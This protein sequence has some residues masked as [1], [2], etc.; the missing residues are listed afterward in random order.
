MA[1][2]FLV[3]GGIAVGVV[4][5]TFGVLQVPGWVTSAQDA[6]ATD[7]LAN[8]RT[9]QALA[10]SNPDDPS[11]VTDFDS[12]RS[13]HFGLQFGLSQNTELTFLDANEDSWCAVVKSGSGEYLAA[14]S[15]AN[16]IGRGATQRLAADSA[17]C[18]AF[19]SLDFTRWIETRRNL[20]VNPRGGWFKPG[21][22]GQF[23]FNRSRWVDRGTYSLEGEWVRFTRHTALSGGYGFH[24]S[25]NPEETYPTSSWLV[26]V[27]PGEEF[28][29]SLLAR[30]S[31]GTTTGFIGWRFTDENNTWVTANRITAGTPVGTTATQLTASFTVPAGA[32]RLA[33]YTRASIADGEIA[34]GEYIEATQL[35]IEKTAA[36]GT[37]FDGG[38]T[39][40]D[41]E[42]TRTRW[43]GEE[44]RSQ[45][46]TETRS[47]AD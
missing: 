24:I 12:L 16:V 1:N 13:G 45:S 36:P 9:A 6:A 5:A 22:D 18:Y 38:T 21:N 39:S 41:P 47:R 3:L 14:G 23:G 44:G 15:D 26:P 43:L 40:A 30:I 33:L 32:T 7:D 37:F 2:P 28:S 10:I 42:L 17:G 20:A 34:D 46:V 27:T 31:Q 19:D 11:F 4:V 35:L 8:I 29:V 25:G